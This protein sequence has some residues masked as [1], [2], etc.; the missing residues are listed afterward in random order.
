[1]CLEVEMVKFLDTVKYVTER[2]PDDASTKKIKKKHKKIVSN[3]DKIKYIQ[4]IIYCIKE[5]Y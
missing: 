2:I 4:K 3:P 1:M 5:I